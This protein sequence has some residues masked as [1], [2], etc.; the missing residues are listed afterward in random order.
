MYLAPLNYDRYFKQVFADENIARQFLED[1]LDVRIES[2]EPLQPRHQFTNDAAIVEFDFRCK[3]ADAYVIVDM[4]QWYKPDIVQRFYV[5]HALNT[6]LQLEHLPR[7]RLI[8]DRAARQV[9]AIKDY[10]AV[11]PVLTL[12]WLVDET[13]QFTENYVAYTMLPEL[14]LEFLK[15]ERLWQEAEIRALL[16]E[17]ERIVN[18]ADNRTKMLDFFQKNRLIFLLQKNIVRNLPSERYARWFR[19]A[20]ASRQPDNREEDF[21]DF[22]GDAVFEE[23]IR[24]LNQTRL[25][26]E[27][28]QYIEHEQEMWAE[29]ERLENGYYETGRHEGYHSGYQNGYKFGETKGLADGMAQGREQG[30]VQGREQGMVQGREQGMV[31]GRAETILSMVKKMAQKGISLEDICEMTGLTT[32]E[33][34]SVLEKMQ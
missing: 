25:T 31:Q 28:W 2:I 6:G 4:Q 3:I 10:R 12:I 15:N 23:M 7:E 27:D 22:R 11:A 9:K 18:L 17:R 5:Y 8:V 21:V 13:L 20:E 24:R 33:V 32:D 16:A 26:D 29:V 30:M 34:L 1:F 14:I 19:F